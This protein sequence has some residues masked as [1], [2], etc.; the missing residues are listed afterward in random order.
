MKKL[1]LIDDAFLRL[2]NR[3]Q[4]LHIGT[5]LLFQP[6]ARARKSFVAD[7]AEK[8]RSSDKALGIYNQRLVDQKGMHYWEEN[9]DFDL[10]HH[11]VHLALPAPGRVRELLAMVSRLHCGH[12]D[13][14]YPLWRLYLIEGL[15]DGRVAVYLKIHHAMVDGISGM[16]ML[17]ETMS[18]S[19]RE[20]ID[21]P[22]FWEVELKRHKG[23]R[24]PVVPAP[25]A[26]GLRAMRAAAREGIKVAAPVMRQLRDLFNDYRKKHPDLALAGAAPRTVFNQPIS[27]TRRF[28]AQSYSAPRIKAVAEAFGATRNDVVLAMVAGALRTYLEERGEL[29]DRPLTGG[30]PVSIRGKSGSGKGAANEVAF[31]I[32][33]LATQID[34]PVERMRAIKRSM[35]YNKEKLSG[36]SSGQT[37]A[38][39]TLSLIPGAISMLLGR[40]SDNTLGNVVVSH[41]PGPRRDLYWQGMKLVGLYPISLL[42]DGGG[43]NITIVS[44]HDLVDFGIIACRKTV[45]HVQRLLTYLEDALVELEKSVARPSR[46]RAPKTRKRAAAQTGKTKAQ[47][48]PRNKP[49]AKKKTAAQRAKR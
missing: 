41:V 22:P 5:L 36:L 29:P 3:R 2:E 37:Q 10:E 9:D 18:P 4:P 15:E 20:S 17:M 28:A 49:A 40:N 11:F 47:K 23:G 45:P 38:F 32:V 13:R 48:N 24:V 16:Q 31:V 21:M 25:A 46:K 6:P 44:R 14:A 8:L 26:S 33:N 7:I 35:D 27:G 34:D 42:I 43:L 19:A 1:H 12:L 39:M 30:V